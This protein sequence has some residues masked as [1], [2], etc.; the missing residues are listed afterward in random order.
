VELEP[1]DIKPRE[2]LAEA[3]LGAGRTDEAAALMVQI[4]DQLTKAKRGKDVARYQQRLGAIAES[5]G[6]LA[7][8]ADSFNGAYKLDPGNPATLAALGRLA[9]REN[10]MEKA[11]KF[12]RSLLLQNFDEVTAGVSKAGVYLAL[13]KIHVLA[14]E[15]PKARNMF[16]RGLENDPKNE[17]LRKALQGLPPN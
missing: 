17:E 6:D 15:I 12:Y 11:R 10:D 5:R 13:G 1:G 2:D 8:A 4:V 14:K 3:L 16:E 7:A 9:L